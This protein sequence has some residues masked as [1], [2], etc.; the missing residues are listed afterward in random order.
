MCVRVREPVMSRIWR[1]K[2]TKSK[3][4][5]YSHEHSVNDVKFFPIHQVKQGATTNK[6]RLGSSVFGRY[7]A[8]IMTLAAEKY[9]CGETNT[10]QNTGYLKK[11]VFVIVEFKTICL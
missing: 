10:Y 4:T 5:L 3:V 11:E 6:G 8:P 9:K 7:L 2:M 1:L